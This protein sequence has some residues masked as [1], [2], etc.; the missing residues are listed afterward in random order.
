VSG[1]GN[2]RRAPRFGKVESDLCAEGVIAL[3]GRRLRQASIG[4]WR[5]SW[6]LPP[7]PCTPGDHDVARGDGEYRGQAH[8]ERRAPRAQRPTIPTSPREA[9]RG[10]QR[11]P[12]K[13]G[14]LSRLVKPNLRRRLPSP[15]QRF[16]GIGPVVSAMHPRGSDLRHRTIKF[17]GYNQRLGAR[18]PGPPRGPGLRALPEGGCHRGPLCLR[19]EKTTLEPLR[20]LG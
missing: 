5:W 13:L 15:R 16:N 6:D 20:K 12:R 3:S 18:T 9:S 10:R 11:R 2:T 8:V 14:R 7:P 19:V 17:V 4:R 1:A